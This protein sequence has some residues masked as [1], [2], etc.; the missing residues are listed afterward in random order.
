MVT[1]LVFAAVVV[2]ALICATVLSLNSSAWMGAAM[3]VAALVG[4]LL[5]GGVEIGQKKKS[6]HGRGA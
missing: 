2:T 6:D 3:I 5:A 1:Q 4:L